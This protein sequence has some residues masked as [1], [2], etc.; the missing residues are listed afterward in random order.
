MWTMRGLS[1][2]MF[3]TTEYLIKH[4]GI[5]TQGFNVTS[6][7][8]DDEQSKRYDQGKFEF[9][10]PSP[11]FVP[12]TVAAII[13]L[14]AFLVGFLEILKGQNWDEF[15]LQM[16]VAGFGILNSLSVYEGMVLRTDKGR[17]A[18]KTTIISTVLASGLYV[19]S[20]A[21]RQM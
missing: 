11:I 5:S 20:S 10:V 4:L 19:A 3:G 15:L 21:I 1:S 17:M 13:N 9:G 14:I 6:K 2:Y 7:L 18:T 12:L 16:F 8:L